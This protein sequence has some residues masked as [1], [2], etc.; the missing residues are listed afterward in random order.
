MCAEKA[1][2]LSNYRFL[3]ESEILVCADTEPSLQTGPG[4]SIDIQTLPNSPEI[5]SLQTIGD[6]E[7]V[8]DVT[9]GCKV[10]NTKPCTGCCF[11]SVRIAL[12][13]KTAKVIKTQLKADKVLLLRVRYAKFYTSRVIKD[14]KEFSLRAD[15]S[16]K[17]N[18]R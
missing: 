12:T 18:G 10:C 2:H 11:K 7:Q 5:S 8:L 3:S 13:E 14:G 15:G 16:L 1:S 6:D 4:D 17:P 9:D